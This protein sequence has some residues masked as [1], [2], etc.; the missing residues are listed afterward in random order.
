MAR[1]YSQSGNTFWPTSSEDVVVQASLPPGTYTVGYSQLRGYYVDRI[2]DFTLPE[3]LY[4][5]V[6]NQARRILTTF[7]SRPATTGVL[8]SGHKGAGKTMLTKRLSQLAMQELGVPTLVVSSPFCGDEF[9]AFIGGMEQ[10]IILLID[11]FEKQYDREQ[12][13]Q[14]LTLFD[15]LY[16]SKKLVLLTCNERSRIDTYMINRP[17]RLYYSLDFTGLSSAFIEEYCEDKLENKD[18]LRGVLNVSAFFSEFSFDMLQGLVEEM[19]RYNETASQAMLM[20]NMRPQNDEGGVYEI[21]GLRNGAVLMSDGQSHDT[22]SRSPLNLNGLEVTFYAFDDGE[23]PEGGLTKS[24]SYQ[25]DV[26]NLINVD[27]EAGLF[28][29]STHDPEVLVQFQRRRR[30]T[31]VMNYEVLGQ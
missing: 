11:E 3:K 15:G 14:L 5:E 26:C 27:V 4:G 25:L 21:Q 9:N 7:Q 8:L 22:V 28:V 12:Q 18:N 31:G 16:S 2:A 29:F 10:D 6:N 13:S 19:N 20:L 1:I 17:G 30:A 24:E 23:A